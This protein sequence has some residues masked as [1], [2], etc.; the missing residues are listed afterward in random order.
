MLFKLKRLLFLTTLS[1]LLPG[2][3]VGRSWIWWFGSWGHNLLDRNS[4]LL[5]S[6]ALWHLRSQLCDP[7][8]REEGVASLSARGYLTP[9][10][11][12]N[13]VR[14]VLRLQPN[15]RSSS[16]LE[17]TS[18]YATQHP[19]I[20]VFIWLALINQ[21]QLHVNLNSI[22]YVCSLGRMQG[23]SSGSGPGRRSLCS[24][25]MVALCPLTWL[26]HKP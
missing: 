13:S 23:P 25:Q 15:Q 16:F 6:D 24:A 4:W 18:K 19:I 5:H 2:F 8:S 26:L 20:V 22:A 10:T 14:R 9:P 12:P 1:Y 17:P 21:N 11:N 7:S 3:W